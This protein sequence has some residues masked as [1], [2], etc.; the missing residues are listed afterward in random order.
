MRETTSFEHIAEI[1]DAKTG[2]KGSKMISAT[3]VTAKHIIAELGN[4]S[5]KK[6]YEI[7]CGNGFLSRL[8]SPKVKEMRASDISS[9]L[10]DYAKN[11]YDSTNIAYE[12]RDAI[13]FTG[14]PKNHFDAIIIHQGIFYIKDID[15]LAQGIYRILKHNGVLIFSNMHPLMYVADIDSNPKIKL[16][17]VLEKYRL[18]LKNRTMEVN[19]TWHVGKEVKPATYHQFKRPFS[20]YTNKLAQHGLPTV[21]IIEPSTVTMIKNKV[22]KSPIPSAMIVKCMKI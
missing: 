16:K 14:L 15:A 12:V 17:P 6:V 19:K 8:L 18:Y 10:I 4:L 20:F 9:K 21:K 1:W 2:N 11:K 7:A 5:N 13:D 22:L 3:K